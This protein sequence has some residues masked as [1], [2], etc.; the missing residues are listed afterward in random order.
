MAMRK[1]KT[2]PWLLPHMVP[3][4]YIALL[5]GL[6]PIHIITFPSKGFC[7]IFLQPH[8]HTCILIKELFGTSFLNKVVLNIDEEKI[9]V[10]LFLMK[11]IMEI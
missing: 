10:C 4:F 9:G 1:Y 3:F 5:L 2:P 6:Y 11:L 7:G 8:Q